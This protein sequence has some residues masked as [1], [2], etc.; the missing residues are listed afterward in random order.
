MP[1]VRAFRH[2][3]LAVSAA[4][5]VLAIVAAAL[6]RFR[7]EAMFDTSSGSVQ[8]STKPVAFSGFDAINLVSTVGLVT[9]VVALVALVASA[10]LLFRILRAG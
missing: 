2:P 10:V 3:A 1:F 9:V 5:A 6:L 8:Y 7:V 4:V